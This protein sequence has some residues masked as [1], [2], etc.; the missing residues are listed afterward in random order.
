M[1]NEVNSITVVTPA[2]LSFATRTG[3]SSWFLAEA[4]LVSIGTL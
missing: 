4:W 3:A 2:S 1:A